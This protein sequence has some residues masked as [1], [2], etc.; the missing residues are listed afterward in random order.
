MLHEAPQRMAGSGTTPVDRCGAVPVSGAGLRVDV[1]SADLYLDWPGRA[2]R[3]RRIASLGPGDVALPL[4]LTQPIA[5]L[6]VDA[7]CLAFPAPG[8]RLS[9]F[10]ID[11]FLKSLDAGEPAAIEAAERWIERTSQAAGRPL[12]G[13]MLLVE[14]GEARLEPGRVARPAQGIL[15][16]SAADAALLT[17]LPGA[18]PVLP[19]MPAVP[20]TAAGVAV[21]R[22]AAINC[23][24]SVALASEGGLSRGVLAHHERVKQALAVAEA[25]REDEEVARIA[26]KGE[27]DRA[28]LAASVA[29]LLAPAAAGALHDA[30]LASVFGRVAR[31]SA[32]ALPDTPWS[33][34]DDHE[35]LPI[36]RQIGALSDWAGVRARRIRLEPGWWR[37]GGQSI[38]GFRRDGGGPVALIAG[39]GW[40]GGYRIREAGRDRP[41]DARVAASLAQDGY[42]V[43]RRLPKTARDGRGLL[44]FAAPLA[45]PALMA[46]GIIGLAGS[47]L[48]LVTPMA[49]EILF[50]TVIPAASQS[51]LLQLTAG[52]AALGLGG[53]VFE[54]VRGF[55]VLRL[56]TLLN[57]D[58]EGAVWDHLLR[59]PAG[60]FRDYTAGDLAL[61]AAAINQ[62]RDAVSGTVVGSLLS[63]V[64]SVSSLALILY[65]E[66]RLA[67]VA[68]GLVVVQLVVMVA[69]NLRM[70]GWKRQALETDGRLQALALQVI[71]GIAKLKVAGAEA[72][73]FARWSPL[74][75]A[76]RSLG[77]R[78]GALSS[79]FSAFGTAFGIASTALLIG[80]VGLGGIE[81]G[82]GRFVAFNAAYGQFVS[83]TLSLGS[84]LPALMSLKPLYGRAAPLLAASPENLGR[85]GAHHD[86]RGGIEVRDVVFRY[87]DGPAV[88]DGVS[89]KAK[90]GEFVGIVGASGSGKSTLMRVLLGFET[91][92]S[93]SVF[94]D[95]Q[96]LGSLDP[97]AL[98]RQMGVVL[99]SSR[100]TS[101]T[102]LDNILN[103]A[104]LTEADA[105]EAARLAGLE[106]D[107][108]AMPM[109]MYTFVGE[110]GTLLSGGQ[111]QR[112]MI[113]RAVVRRPRI[114]LFDEAT[115]AL[116][117]RTQQIVSEGLE[118]LDATRVVIAHRLSTIQHADRIY[119]L[120]GGRV[121]EEGTYR[122][123]LK[124]GGLFAQLA[125]RQV[126]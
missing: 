72:R 107:I 53:I 93:G 65:Y 118:W 108:R 21:D 122:E 69:V 120:Q 70:L 25:S 80:I 18:A 73:A 17:E 58:L 112:L 33:A 89:I 45:W 31:A 14:A 102:L 40:R 42:I 20:V 59:L 124:R 64:F 2:G 3:R 85:Q 39:T 24:S 56:S 78:Q 16:A 90:P 23:R 96:D 97:R 32:V 83:A 94:F 92:E 125:L 15:W 12:A 75:I 84:V 35:R 106:A 91:P 28:A 51:E 123:L 7:R 9:S 82:I 27:R 116:D 88:L 13:T 57:T 60:F 34:S 29:P 41:V 100:A 68:I 49:T 22:A 4:S 81:I 119:V 76:R 77:F 110:D 79:G 37:R 126:A 19:A 46:I 66:W 61:R 99:Q 26:G 44:R 67:L 63:A 11:P 74:F 71:Q 1:G 121:A 111:R 95:D 5:G 30:S 103:G 55:L 105:W 54:L 98:R 8:S 104:A 62:M 48:G 36:D 101:G 10:A 117:N 50:E 114:L 43:Q 115:S 52:I 6:P 86:L 38:V 47:L 113:A 87:R 109:R